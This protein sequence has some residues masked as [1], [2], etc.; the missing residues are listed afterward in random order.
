M[1]VLNRLKNLETKTN[2]SEVCE[3]LGVKT[4]IRLN[5]DGIETCE[6]PLP[7]FCDKCRKPLEKAII[8]LDFTNKE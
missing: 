3:C 6:N 7:D 2:T 1:N 8:I 5:V 4:E